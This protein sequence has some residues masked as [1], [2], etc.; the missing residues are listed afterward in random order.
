MEQLDYQ[1][2]KREVKMNDLNQPNNNGLN[3][4]S[5]PIP[6]NTEQNNNGLNTN[7]STIP[8]YNLNNITGNTNQQTLGQALNQNH[9]N[10]DIRC[11]R[12]PTH[13]NPCRDLWLYQKADKRQTMSCY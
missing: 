5:Q 1:N 8:N 7:Q 3:L 6:N 13:G 4:N 12:C 9:I 11:H 2:R 10:Q